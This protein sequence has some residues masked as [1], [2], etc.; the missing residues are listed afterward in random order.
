MARSKSI[1]KTIKP[2]YYM[3]RTMGF[4]PFKITFNRNVEFRF[5][6]N[7]IILSL[8]L[9]LLIFN[10]IEFV[11]IGYITSDFMIFF[12]A[13]CNYIK[14]A[15]TIFLPI[16]LHKSST[17]VWINLFKL[18]QIL[19][20]NGIA[21]NFKLYNIIIIGLFVSYKHIFS[22]CELLS[23]LGIYDS[24]FVVTTF[25]I[26]YLNM[27]GLFT[28][29]QIIFMTIILEKCF[30]ILDASLNKEMLQKRNVCHE[31]HQLLCDTSRKEFVLMSPIIL[32]L[33]AECFY[34]M[35]CYSFIMIKFMS[36]SG[37]PFIFYFHMMSSCFEAVVLLFII[38]FTATNLSKSVSIS[39]LSC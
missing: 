35:V 17:Q 39:F 3:F 1:I 19:T 32:V 33:F 12:L 15:F 7:K 2:F 34:T 21:W 29:F 16:I 9:I 14:Y 22:I 25:N 13:T 20:T 10:S 6:F 8:N 37:I 5:H 18:Q 27:H 11:M 36:I 28:K 26:I 4:L 23:N 24:H 38:I 30:T 31:M